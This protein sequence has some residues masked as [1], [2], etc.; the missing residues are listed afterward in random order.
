L[1]NVYKIRDASTKKLSKALETCDSLNSSY[2]HIVLVYLQPF[3]RN[4]LLKCA[5]QPKIAK[6]SPKPF[7]WRFKVVQG[8]R[9]W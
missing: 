1:K 4:L 7:F 5:L 8:H 3:R 9:C 2:L 6:N